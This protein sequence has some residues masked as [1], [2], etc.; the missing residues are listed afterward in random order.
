MSIL[1]AEE[2]EDNALRA[3]YGTER[4]IRQPSRI[5]HSQL[6]SRIEHFGTILHDAIQSDGVVRGKY[7][8]W[9]EMIGLLGGDEVRF[10]LSL[11]IYHVANFFSSI[12]NFN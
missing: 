12:A 8:D 3:Q 2:T 6:L 9:S 7:G 10:F 4:W 5:A 1:K 11:L